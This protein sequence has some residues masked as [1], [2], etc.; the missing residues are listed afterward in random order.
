MRTISHPS[1]NLPKELPNNV[2]N[3]LPFPSEEANIS[4]RHKWNYI[5]APGVWLHKQ[6]LWCRYVETSREPR[7]LHWN[8]LWKMFLIYQT[9]GQNYKGDSDLHKLKPERILCL[10]WKLCWFTRS[11]H[12][13]SVNG[14]LLCPL[15]THVQRLTHCCMT[16]CNRS[17][18]SFWR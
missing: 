9:L 7:H 3:I 11:H 12:C 17:V 1:T 16:L 4:I 18:W 13:T 8:I 10:P 5:H 14:L 2:T 15:N 6:S